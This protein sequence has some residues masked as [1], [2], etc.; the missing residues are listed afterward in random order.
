MMEL[1]TTHIAIYMP[2]CHGNLGFKLKQSLGL[3]LFLFE[4][5]ISGLD[6]KENVSLLW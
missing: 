5:N 1:S 3:W 6:S 4:L 2:F